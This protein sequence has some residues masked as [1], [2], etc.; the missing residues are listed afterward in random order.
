MI[1]FELIDETQNIEFN[2]EDNSQEIKFDLTDYDDSK[3]KSEISNLQEEINNIPIQVYKGS[4]TPDS[5]VLIWIDTSGE[6]PIVVENQLTTKDGL[7]FLTKD[8]AYFILK[9]E[10]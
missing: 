3:L 4:N 5:D 10:I 1:E 8:N 7:E 2:L 9:E 6:S